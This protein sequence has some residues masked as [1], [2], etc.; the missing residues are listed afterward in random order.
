[1]A[2]G[3]K[4]DVPR[5]VE[6]VVREEASLATLTIA[7]ERSTNPISEGVVARLA[8]ALAA[9]NESSAKA[10]CLC[11]AGDTFSAGVDVPFVIQCLAEGD[12][13]RLLR[14]GRAA[15]GLLAALER[16]NKLVVAW[17]RGPAFGA[18]LELA[19]ACHRI[20]A[21]P[22]AKFALP[23]TGLGIYP[24]MGGTQR[25]PRRVGLGLAKWMI[26]TGAIIPA[27]QAL[28]IGLID[29]I[30]PTASTPREALEAVDLP[31]KPISMGAKFRALERLFGD[32]D[33]NSL[34][35]PAFPLPGEPQAVRALVQLRSKAPL[36]LRLV[37]QIMDR[38]MTLPIDEAIDEEF[39]HL[40]QIFSSEDARAGLAS[41]GN[42]R[43]EFVGR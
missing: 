20:V 33:V 30:H 14:F 42:A 28:E 3:P 11:G 21:S 43:P 37:E 12:L 22:T 5:P 2:E 31:A 4:M 29:A 7:G 32:N 41:L 9:A 40:R 36:A 6:M 39:R 19:L 13:D 25:T 27:D 38:G 26:Y 18:G 17:V 16:A 10:I 8:D 35:N 34:A 24:G 1:M 23:E 15:Q